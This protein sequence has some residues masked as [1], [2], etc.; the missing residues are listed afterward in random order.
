M[1]DL[2][3][4]VS[5]DPRAEVAVE[6]LDR[7]AADHEALRG[8]QPR[9][10]EASA[11][12]VR[13]R[14]LGR[15]TPTWGVAADG[16]GWT[17]WAGTLNRRPAAM[18]A[19]LEALEGQ[20]SLVRLGADGASVEVATDALG[21]KPLFVAVGEAETHVSTS[22]LVL[23]RHLGARPSLAG[24]E[25]FL[26]GGIQ[27][28]RTTQWEGIER[29]RPAEVRRFDAGGGRP[30]PA[31]SSLPAL[32]PE[33]AS[34]SLAEAAELCIERALPAL[35][36]RYEGER[37]WV[38]LTGGF[39]SR[40]L[41]LLVARA[42]AEPIANTFG[43]PDDED[44]RI[45][46]RIALA[47]DWP[48]TRIG[49]PEDWPQ[50]LPVEVAGAVAWG[51][52][53]LDALPL[54]GVLAGHREK[55][56]TAS[57]LLNGGGGE[58]FRDHPWGHELWRAGRST[59]VDYARL[60]A[61][62][63]LLPVD[64]SALRADPTAAATAL[65]R[66]ELEA[67]VAPFAGRPNTFQDDLLYAYKMTGHS[68]A[69]QAAA[70]AT[71]DLEVPFYLRPILLSA[72]SVAPRHRRFHSLMRAMMRATRPRGG[73]AADRDRRPG[74]AAAPRQPAALRRVRAAAGR[75]L[76][77]PR[78]R[79]AAELRQRR[80]AAPGRPAGSRRSRPGR[81]AASRR[82]PRRGPDAGGAAV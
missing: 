37:L 56:A 63:I 54:A 34:L 79:P 75:A 17:A 25:V 81:G 50:R 47:R 51:D 53:H 62:R 64:L 35:A 26:R 46:R 24:I 45:A 3:A 9:S 11:G 12:R 69:Y 20:F 2:L 40:L 30:A 14:L 23:A 22:A 32:Q 4:I 5:H 18:T 77:V 48:W 58:E 73:G 76:R 33:I 39:D 10:A 38:D 70:G 27:F 8:P 42:G 55:A 71:I 13:V 36:E 74:R 41:S 78:P 59:E 28:G 29:L 57:L 66:E 31:T 82:P 80:R 19:P 16:A 15:P 67:R 49:L 44:V 52:G 43:G 72:I 1:A 61:W 21:M 65:L 7:L 68:G 60:I 6:A